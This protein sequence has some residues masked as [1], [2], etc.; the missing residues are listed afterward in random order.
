MIRY[1]HVSIDVPEERSSLEDLSNDSKVF[2]LKEQISIDK[3][4]EA[5]CVVK[6]DDFREQ[7]SPPEK[8]C[9]PFRI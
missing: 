1:Q 8:S 6:Y 7:K 3:H 4:G 5:R 2:V 9:S